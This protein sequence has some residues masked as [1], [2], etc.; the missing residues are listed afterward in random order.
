MD[1]HNHS[2]ISS[3]SITLH[4]IFYKKSYSIKVVEARENLDNKVDEIFYRH[5]ISC[6]SITVGILAE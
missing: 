3:L 2:N 5:D 1:L 6:E 4:Y